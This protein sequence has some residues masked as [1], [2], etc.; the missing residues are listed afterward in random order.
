MGLPDRDNLRRQLALCYYDA[1]VI[2]AGNAGKVHGLDR[3]GYEWLAS[4][5]NPGFNETAHG[6]L[7]NTCTEAS[8][9]KVLS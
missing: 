4:F 9:A 3:R 7:S 5:Q 8:A 2:R 6:G 1:A